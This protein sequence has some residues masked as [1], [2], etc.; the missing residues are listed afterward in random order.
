MLGEVAPFLVPQFDAL[1]V[2]LLAVAGCVVAIGLVSIIHRVST[3]TVGAVGLLLGHVPGVGKVLASPV[4]AVVQWM[5]HEFSAAE[6]GLDALLGRYLH[7]VARLFAWVGHE[8]RAHSHLLYVLSTVAV[9]SSSIAWLYRLIVHGRETVHAVEARALAAFGL[10]HSIEQQMRHVTGTA[11]HAAIAH[12]ARPIRAEVSALDSWVH[13]RVRGLGHAVT[14]TLPHELSTLRGR[15]RALEG[16]EAAL[17]SRVKRLE[18]SLTGA[19]VAALVAAGLAELGGSWIRC[20]NWRG[21]GRHVCGGLGGL[22]EPLLENAI[23]VLIVADLCE[24]AKVIQ[25]A[26]IYFEPVLDELVN[27]EAMVCLAG[28]AELASG[29]VAADLHH[30]GGHPTAITAHDL[31]A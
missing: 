16:E 9:G 20:R 19:G 8:I 18:H 13:S 7:A 12:V 21:I 11:L 17:L 27:A 15:A 29:I 26:A 14:S 5:D 6:Q 3:G 24:V 23:E 10:A 4:N 31:A 28:G 22:L 2:S 1:L 30:P 25:S